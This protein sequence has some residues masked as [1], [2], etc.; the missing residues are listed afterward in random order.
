M[1]LLAEKEKRI[2]MS[3]L[4]DYLDVGHDDMEI[5]E[6]W[7]T[8]P[9][10]HRLVIRKVDETGYDGGHVDVPDEILNRT[11]ALGRIDHGMRIISF[12]ENRR[13]KSRYSSTDIFSVGYD[14]Q[15]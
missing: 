10:R 5:S 2:Y 13:S 9:P 15:K 3:L 4:Y 6:Y 11:I 1:N 14:L 12:I 7:Y 8:Q